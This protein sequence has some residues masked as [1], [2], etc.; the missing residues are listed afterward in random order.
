MDIRYVPDAVQGGG[1]TRTE[2]RSACYASCTD[3]TLMDRNSLSRSFMRQ[4]PDYVA[5]PA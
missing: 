2:L 5:M 1:G 3:D 4:K